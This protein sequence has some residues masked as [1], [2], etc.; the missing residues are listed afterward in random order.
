MKLFF[1]RHGQSENN[2]LWS[3]TQSNLNRV[4]DP[5]LT[6]IG[7]K[8]VEASAEFLIFYSNER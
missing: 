8:Q 2:A 5:Q 7:R 4:S 6:E 1:V 3:D